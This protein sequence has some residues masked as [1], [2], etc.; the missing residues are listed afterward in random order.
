MTR[1]TVRGEDYIDS[2]KERNIGR[3]TITY[4]RNHQQWQPKTKSVLTEWEN[5]HKDLLIWNDRS[6]VKQKSDEVEVKS[7]FEESRA[8]SY[9]MEVLTDASEND[10]EEKKL[11]RH[12]TFDV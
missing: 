3:K 1:T 7:E 8:S 5:K 2:F 4:K 11:E 10:A 6:D 9:E 12:D